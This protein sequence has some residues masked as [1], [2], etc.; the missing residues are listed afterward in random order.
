[1]EEMEC[2]H[3]ST[4]SGNQ[5]QSIKVRL[6]IKQY[7]RLRG[8]TQSWLEVTPTSNPLRLHD[9]TIARGCWHHVFYDF[10]W[11]HPVCSRISPQEPDELNDQSNNDL[12]G[13][14]KMQV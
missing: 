14:M 8:C 10:L 11:Q 9:G 7:K 5:D 3:L 6:Q 4:E 12:T 1:M 13:E 2:L